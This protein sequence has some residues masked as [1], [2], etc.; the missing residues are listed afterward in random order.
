M[1]ETISFIVKV[2]AQVPVEIM[3]ELQAELNQLQNSEVNVRTKLLRK[4]E[5]TLPETIN[6]AIQIVTQANEWVGSATA[7][8]LALHKT[9]TA[10]AEWRKNQ[11]DKNKSLSH[12]PEHSSTEDDVKLVVVKK[13]GSEVTISG[14]PEQI[15]AL[16]DW[17]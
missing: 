14:T 16:M 2:S 4:Q 6:L 9:V 3:T 12:D 5:S 1:P 11:K 7:A 15:K 8:A 10:L 17:K 13:D